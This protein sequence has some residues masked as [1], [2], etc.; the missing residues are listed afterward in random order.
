MPR[1]SA[2]TAI[3]VPQPFP[4]H[5]VK[6]A[7]VALAP[8]SWSE[9]RHPHFATQ[10]YFFAGRRGSGK[11]Y[12][13][14]VLCES[15]LDAGV[16]VIVIDPVG[17]WWGLQLAAD[18]VS[19]AYKIPVLGGDHGNLELPTDA[20]AV[21]ADML[22]ETGSSAVLDLS[23]MRK[24]E[25]KR[26]M[27]QWGEQFFHRKKKA[28]SACHVFIEESH[29][30]L[31]QMA[32]PDDKRMLGALEDLV[33]LGRNYGIGVTMIDQRPQ[34]VSKEAVN[35]AECLA[36]FQ[37]VGPQERDAI[38]KWTE[39][40]EAAMGEMGALSS[41]PTGDCYLWSP[42]WLKVTQKT[43]FRPKKTYDASSTP[44][45]GHGV[46]QPG[47]VQVIPLDLSKLEAAMAAARKEAKDN[48]PKEL[49]KQVAQLHTELLTANAQLAQLSADTD[50]RLHRVEDENRN[51]ASYEE[52]YR[53]A[54]Q[55]LAAA[56]NEID[57]SRE[58][59]ARLVVQRRQIR[60]ATA[61]VTTFMD[62]LRQAT[63]SSVGD[64]L[65]ELGTRLGALSN[66]VM[67]GQ[68]DTRF[69]AEVRKNLAVDA[70]YDD[71][72]PPPPVMPIRPKVTITTKRFE[73]RTP[74]PR[75]AQRE[76]EGAHGKALDMEIVST[77]RAFRRPLTTRQLAVY[78]GRADRTIQNKLVELRKHGLVTTDSDYHAITGAGISAVGNVKAMSP[79]ER[80]SMWR[81]KLDGGARAVFDVL[82]ERRR[83]GRPQGETTVYLANATGM[84]ER[85]VQNC[86][87][88]LRTAL[89]V[90]R[91]NPH[92]L[93]DD[94]FTEAP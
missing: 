66:V 60:E 62:H 61:H 89:L 69:D 46:D 40:K 58:R 84:A 24:A 39:S 29:L 82:L 59:E 30:F 63:L 8:W 92:K 52:A 77:L 14:G 54:E 4:D 9:E 48:D 44:T 27:E 94:L 20:G 11:S 10:V 49:K 35:Q 56:R 38:K 32:G 87:V 36:V 86:L 3:T 37:L 78:T 64:V 70:A 65:A 74:V 42:Q 50:S 17:T 2:T 90:L 43:R 28:R 15:M 53:N 16:Q 5:P 45:A 88:T 76:I 12:G 26:F 57:R 33:R 81:T 23:D 18:G 71:V 19:P 41:L 55:D 31:P 13:A 73:S 91:G 80:V 25:R 67:T 72:F 75:S 6:V 51:L 21:V 1:R 34:S 93:N 22:V 85:T 83:L 79:A 68:G 47:A 7:P